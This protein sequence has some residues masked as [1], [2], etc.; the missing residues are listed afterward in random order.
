MQGPTRVAA[1]LLAFIV[2]SMSFAD[3]WSYSK[4]YHQNPKGFFDV[5][6]GVAPAPTQYRIGVIMPADF[7]ARHTHLGLRHVFTAIDACAGFISVFTLFLLFRRSLV[8]R[9]AGTLPR[10]FGSACF[11]VLVQFYMPWLTWYQRPETM[12]TAAIIS[13]VFLMLTMRL[14]LPGAAGVVATAVGMLVLAVVQGFVRADVAFALHVGILLLCLTP[15]GERLSLPRGVQMVTSMLAVLLTVGIQYYMM[16][17][18]YPQAKYDG[19]AFQ[20]IMNF[21]E[22][23]R[24]IAFILF[25]LPYAWTVKTLLRWR[26]QIE[27]PAMA[28]VLGSAVFMGMWWCVGRVEEVRIFLPFALALAPLGAELAMR[29]W[30]GEVVASTSV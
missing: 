10:W 12:T 19:A 8:Y 27:A 11:L 13:L 24:L 7:V 4:A 6:E 16:H 9:D 3:Y 17:I 23:T 22:W 20:L 18:V 26:A 14:P 30:S 2:L 29:Q 1:V 5:V 15:A 25:I 28:L 21:E